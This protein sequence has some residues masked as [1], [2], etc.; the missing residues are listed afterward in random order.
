MALEQLSREDRAFAAHVEDLF[1]RAQQKYVT[2]FTGFLD[3]HQIR[4]AQW[5]ANAS[6][7]Q[8]YSFYAGH[9][10][11]ERL[12]LGVFAPYEPVEEAQFPIVPL[13]VTFRKEDTVGHRD[14]LG[15]LLGLQLKREAIGDILLSPG[16]AVCFISRVFAPLVLSELKKVGRV[17]VKVVEGAP[18]QL[19]ALHHYK[20]LPVNVSS[21][22]LDCVVAAVCGFSRERASTAIRAGLA[23]VNG[24]AQ[25]DVS[26][27]LDEGDVLSVRGVGKFRFEKVLSTTKKGRLQLLCKKYV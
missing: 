19:P 5:V 6:G 1:Q 2:C 22:R 21:L 3:L 9:P 27:L 18:E 17:G 12:M 14:L 25:E 13:T 11:G 10:D 15:S 23:T 7:Y 24:A 20:D 4:L 8:S 26:H 16:L